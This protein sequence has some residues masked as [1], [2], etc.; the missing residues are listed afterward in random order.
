MYV[1]T[2]APG[3]KKMIQN[4]KGFLKNYRMKKSTG[5]KSRGQ[6]IILVQLFWSYRLGLLSGQY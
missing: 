3:K 6:N 1:F 2:K 4:Y 5:D